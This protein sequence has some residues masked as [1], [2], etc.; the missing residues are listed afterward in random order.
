MRL[1]IIRHG[2]PDYANDCLT[3]KGKKE[4]LLLAEK[5]KK[6]KLDYIYT[7]PLGRAKETCMYAMKA[8]GRENEVQIEPL[9]REF[10]RDNS[11][12]LPDGNIRHSI[13]DLLPAYWTKE[14]VFYDCEKWKTHPTLEMGDVVE[15]YASVTNR[16]DEILKEHGYVREERYY[17]V[18]K[19]NTDTLVIFCHFGVEMILLSHLFNVSPFPLLH[20]FVALTTSVTTLFTEERREGIASFRCCGFGDISHLYAGEELPSF[21]ARFCETFGDGTRQD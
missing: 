13:W 1:L 17:R 2:D 12:L 15:S 4:A 18:E 11:M 6:E 9:F 3:E 19:G 21:S 8:L 20:H 10:T 16:L 7:S 14:D 5:L